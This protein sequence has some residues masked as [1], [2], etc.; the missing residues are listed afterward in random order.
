MRN[1]RPY[2]VIPFLPVACEFHNR[3]CTPVSSLFFYSSYSSIGNNGSND[4]KLDLF[5]LVL[6]CSEV[7][8]R[9]L[10]RANMHKKDENV[11]PFDVVQR[12]S[13]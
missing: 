9:L 1:A 7:C 3:F 6:S 13:R 10:P 8:T 4:T 5:N 2:L 12:S 11:A